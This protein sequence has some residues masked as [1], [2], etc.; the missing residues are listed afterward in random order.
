MIQS[1]TAFAR[2]QGQG[3]W[4]SAVC[5]VRSINHRYLECV[6]RL[7][8]ALH[9][10]ET[11][12]RECIRHYIK[13]GK[14]EFHLRYQPSDTTGTEMTINHSLVEQLCK[15]NEVIAT[16]LKQPAPINTMDILAW[17]G[18]LELAEI[19]LEMIQ[20]QVI[21]LLEKALQELVAARAREGEELKKLF[22]QRLD[23]M[24]TEVAK[25]REH[26]PEILASQRERLMARFSDAKLELDSGRLEQEIVL[27]AQKTDV[28]EELDRIDSHVSEV[29]RILKH[30]GV[31]G[32]RLDFLMQ[33]LHREAN[34][35]G[36]KSTNMDTTRA[37]VELKVLIEQVR[38]Q[39]QNIE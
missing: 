2:T 15:A 28:M 5:E 17:P 20:D 35:L 14:I 33:E 1:M 9:E 18:V 10:L 37:S 38:E 12:L 31:L 7:P 16:R 26:L 30:G 23:S 29:R 36:A 25:V 6:I 3:T 34:T 27:F 19:D 8:E 13:R 32:R 21:S 39:V 22:L 24:K 11:P 4:G